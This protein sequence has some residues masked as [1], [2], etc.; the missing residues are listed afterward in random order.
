[1]NNVFRVEIQIFLITL[2]LGKKG[3]RLTIT[4]LSM[5]FLSYWLK[6]VLWVI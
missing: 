5:I 6:I 1:M 3:S 2:Y 4:A